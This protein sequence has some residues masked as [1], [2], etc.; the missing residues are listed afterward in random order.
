MIPS[1][2]EYFSTK[3]F[4][5]THTTDSSL[6]VQN[7]KNEFAEIIKK[8]GEKQGQD[9]CWNYVISQKT[10][11]DVLI[12]AK[13]FSELYPLVKSKQTQFIFEDGSVSLSS[14]QIEA[15]KK[16]SKTIRELLEDAEGNEVPLN[17]ISKAQFLAMLNHLYPNESFAK[18]S[19]DLTDKIIAANYLHINEVF[20]SVSRQFDD[21]IENFKSEKD[22]ANAFNFLQSIRKLPKD[23]SEPLELKMASYFGRVFHAASTNQKIDITVQYQ[24]MQISALSFAGLEKLNLETLFAIPSL[25]VLNLERTDVTDETIGFIPSTITD[26]NLSSCINIT[27]KGLS[28][29]PRGLIKLNLAV[30]FNI[31]EKEIEGF[32]NDLPGT[33]ESLHFNGENVTDAAVS[34]LPRSI[35]SIDFGYCQKLTD[36]AISHLPVNLLSLTLKGSKITN[37]GLSRLPRNLNHLDLSGCK[38]IDDRGLEN[39]P[40]GLESLSLESFPKIT[41]SGISR[42][43][44][45]VKTLSLALCPEISDEGIEALPKNLESLDLSGCDKITSKSLGKLPRTL[46]NLDLTHCI[47]VNDEGLDGLPKDLVSLN[48]NYCEKVT[49]KGLGKLPRKLTVL[50][51]L[52]C[53]EITDAGLE[54]LPAS[55]IEIDISHNDKITDKGVG[56]L[57]RSVRILKI[58]MC[59]QITDEGLINLPKDLIELQVSYSKISEKGLR[60]LPKSIKRINIRN[61]ERIN[62]TAKE[63]L[64][65]RIFVIEE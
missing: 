63:S 28:K 35:K 5:S 17:F 50:S 7:I 47:E 8:S 46:K 23:I 49:D 16:D 4:G 57:P 60:N 12:A 21:Q 29:L 33:L 32:F 25:R 31:S 38:N 42:I 34:R 15:L 20:D 53:K 37:E 10:G 22:L 2:R 44:R 65:M 19:V 40:E 61:C 43:P 55:L 64:K 45:G 30:T 58:N 11:K 9:N 27:G 62:K 3:F 13:V 52:L 48:L 14:V 56:K 51:L 26:L 1:L 54:G 24:A 59:S 41:N 36:A 39:L 18:P 6:T